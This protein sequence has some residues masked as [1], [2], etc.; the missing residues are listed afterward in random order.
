MFRRYAINSSSDQR[1]AVEMLEKNRL[2]NARRAQ[3]DGHDFSHD[4]APAT[5][6]EGA[7]LAPKVN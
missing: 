5:T 7:A 1:A 3:A 6:N 2:E 4:P